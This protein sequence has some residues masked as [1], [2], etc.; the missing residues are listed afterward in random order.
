MDRT[1]K[2][3]HPG[4]NKE[5]EWAIHHVCLIWY[6]S[7]PGSLTAVSR[8]CPRLSESSSGLSA[9]LHLLRLL[10]S[11]TSYSTVQPTTRTLVSYIKGTLPFKV[12]G[13][14]IQ[15]K[16]FMQRKSRTDFLENNQLFLFSPALIRNEY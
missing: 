12:C 8:V 7:S 9:A 10:S 15:L 16:D 13:S 4:L 6:P 1:V 5:P 3:A 2:G 11:F 14:P